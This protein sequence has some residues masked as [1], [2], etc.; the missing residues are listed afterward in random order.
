MWDNF[1]QL[2]GLNINRQ[3]VNLDTQFLRNQFVMAVPLQNI[4][5]QCR[6]GYDKNSA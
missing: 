4:L 6:T 1:G 3:M 2:N 5:D